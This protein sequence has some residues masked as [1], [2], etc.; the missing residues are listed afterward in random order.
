LL[1]YDRSRK[2]DAMDR[3]HLALETLARNEAIEWL[4]GRVLRNLASRGEKFFFLDALAGQ[5]PSAVKAWNAWIGEFRGVFRDPQT[6]VQKADAELMPGTPQR[7]TSFMTE[8]LAVVELSRSGYSNFEAVI[9]GDKPMPDYTATKGERS[10]RIEVKD[11]ADP[12]DIIRTVA[13]RRW[14]EQQ[15]KNPQRYAFS[16]LVSHTHTGPL[17]DAAI[18]RLRTIVDQLPDFASGERREIL[19]GAVPITVRRVDRELL[20]TSGPEGEIFRQ[21][22]NQG[23]RHTLIVQSALL[24]RHFEPNLQEVQ[25]LFIKAFRTV[26]DATPKFFGRQFIA[27]TEN[28]IV[29][30]WDPPNMFYAEGLLEMVQDAIEKAFKA[31]QLELKVMIQVGHPNPDF[32]HFGP[33][34]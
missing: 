22:T 33:D 32:S 21:T 29:L 8:V 27:E 28:I 25:S 4:F 31:A 7:L 18:S 20:E 19:D 13:T 11:L 12:E 10:V 14:A 9:A 24:V 3:M 2:E 17:S 6:A 5:N 30:A 23:V 1:L 16:A 26:G 15:A 34:T